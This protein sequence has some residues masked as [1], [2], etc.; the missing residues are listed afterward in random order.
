MVKCNLEKAQSP[1]KQTFLAELNL[2]SSSVRE[3]IFCLIAFTGAQN[4][5]ILGLGESKKLLLFYK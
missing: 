1:W 2:L 4:D 3:S 5:S